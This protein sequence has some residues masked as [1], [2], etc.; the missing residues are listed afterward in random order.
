MD[1]PTVISSKEYAMDFNRWNQMQNRFELK[2]IDRHK[3]YPKSLLKD[4][5]KWFLEFAE[6][7]HID[8]SP[9]KCAM[10]VQNDGV[11]WQIDF[12]DSRLIDA[13]GF[14]LYQIYF[15]GRTRKIM[16]AGWGLG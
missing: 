8:A 2:C 9:Y 11:T 1:L 15:D 3:K 4:A 16:Q 14:C 5:W 6:R 13:A 7:M 12:I 10:I